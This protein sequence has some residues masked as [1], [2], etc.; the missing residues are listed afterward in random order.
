MSNTSGSV[1]VLTGFLGAKNNTIE[2]F[3]QN[4]MEEN[5]SYS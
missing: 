3:L 1:T 4:S 5:S 2:S